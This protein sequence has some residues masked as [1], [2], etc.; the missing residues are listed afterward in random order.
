[1]AAK[2][3]RERNICLSQ[4]DGALHIE[5]SI[6]KFADCTAEDILKDKEFLS[7]GLVKGAVYTFETMMCA[8]APAESKDH[9]QQ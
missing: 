7:Y 9:V 6:M 4:F 8:W 3:K 5:N 1:M 2:R